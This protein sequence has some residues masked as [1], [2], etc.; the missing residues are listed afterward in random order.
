MITVS[1]YHVYKIVARAFLDRRVCRYRARQCPKNMAH[2]F[3]WYRPLLRHLTGIWPSA[4]RL[5]KTR[6]IFAHTA[7]RG[8]LSCREPYGPTA[9]SDGLHNALPHPP[10]SKRQELT[11][12][13]EFTSSLYKTYVSLVDKVWQ[14]KATVLVVL[15]HSHHKAKIGCG[16]PLKSSAVTIFYPFKQRMFLF[17]R[18]QTYTAN[19]TQIDVKR[20]T[21]IIMY[22]F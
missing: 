4:M 3:L 5:L 13:V 18:E 17:L 15:G 12:T 16:K 7:C 1:S 10:S 9:L 14:T 8:K 22:G 11:L 6:S 19:L 2:F 20:R 21:V